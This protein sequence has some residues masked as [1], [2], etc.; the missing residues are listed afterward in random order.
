MTTATVATAASKKKVT[1]RTTKTTTAAAP[2]SKQYT[3]ANSQ[4][5][6]DMS[7]CRLVHNNQ[8]VGYINPT[9][10]AKLLGLKFSTPLLPSNC[11]LYQ[12]DASQETF[13]I[14]LPPASR[15]ISYHKKSYVVDIDYWQYYRISFCGNAFT[16]MHIFISKD[17]VTNPKT[18]I[19]MMRFLNHVG[20]I[21]WGSVNPGKNLTGDK[22]LH[23]IT[24]FWSSDFSDGH[25]TPSQLGVNNGTGKLKVIQDTSYEITLG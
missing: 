8:Q 17:R 20:H 25:G 15:N 19:P 5:V 6:L 21:C 24:A 23:R 11:V 13:I 7:S 12:R 10:L 4:V 3:L 2:A 18:K 9:E 1:R 16:G 22:C 14:E